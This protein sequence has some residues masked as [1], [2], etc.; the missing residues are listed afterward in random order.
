MIRFQMLEGEE[1]E[2]L[3]KILTIAIPHDVSMEGVILVATAI[4]TI[5][6]TFVADK[7]TGVVS[8]Q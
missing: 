8:E 7:V 6:E 2:K 4:Q 3:A 1:E 5:R